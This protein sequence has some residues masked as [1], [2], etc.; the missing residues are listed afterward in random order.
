MKSKYSVPAILILFLFLIVPLSAE[1]RV[2]IST[3]HTR[4]INDLIMQGAQ[5][6]LFSAGDDGTLRVW[7]VN[8]LGDDRGKLLY[9]LQIS[10]LPIVKIAVHPTLPQVALIETDRI[11]TFHLSVWDYRTGKELFSHKIEEVPLFIQYSP[12]GTYLIYGR[13]KWKSMTILNS[14]TGT[15]EPVLENGFGIVTGI[16]LSSTE[17]T[18]LSY[19]PSG[20]IRYWNLETGE[21]K[22]SFSTIGD[23]LNIQFAENGVYMIGTR[24]RYVYLINLVNG[25]VEARQEFEFLR[26]LY[27]DAASNRLAIYFTEK[28]RPRFQT[29]MIEKFGS[30]WSLNPVNRSI[31]A[32]DFAAPPLILKDSTILFCRDNGEMYT[33]SIYSSGESVFSSSILLKVSDIGFYNDSILVAGYEYILKLTSK[34]F[35]D[36]ERDG[37][38]IDVSGRGVDFLTERYEN[39]IGAATGLISIDSRRFL[40]FPKSESGSPLYLFQD[41][42]FSPLDTILTG[43]VQSAI[44][45]GRDVL[46]LEKSG[47]LRI[48][49]PVSGEEKFSY[50]SFGLQSAVRSW[51]N[52]ILVARNQTDLINTTL[53]SVDPETSETVPIPDRN[54]LTFHLAYDEA[55]RSLFSL[56][57][58]NRRGSIRTV[59]KQHQGYAYTR[60]S[61]LLSYPGEDNGATLTV[62]EETGRVFTSLGYGDVHMFTWDG[63]STMEK[64][65]HIP[66]LLHTHEGR[67]FSLNGDSSISIWNVSNGK[68]QMTLNVFKDL[69]WT[70]SFADGSFYATDEARRWIY[71]VE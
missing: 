56:G 40:I 27:L 38:G 62:D 4:S 15:V 66:R 44:P 41:G 71:T 43:P 68:L 20:M 25:N 51:D 52:N 36:S 64:V 54:L 16:F 63:F 13:T 57:F 35:G 26:G 58:E 5:N 3:G 9:K 18:L 33:H 69:S 11:N 67:L 29:F 48:I 61:T 70:V 2:L 65:E 55:T 14:M 6:L 19:S 23:L 10:H 60:V 50:S 22:T 37:S 53:L 46:L 21:E 32:P 39:P 34:V 30:A 8:R 1:Q 24:G 45:Y 49:D 42:F 59:L 47:T 31:S 28:S 7:D 12:M 17:K